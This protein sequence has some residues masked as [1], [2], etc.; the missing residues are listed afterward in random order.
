MS[1][2]VEANSVVAR[3][4]SLE[5]L[6]SGGLLGYAYDCPNN[7]FCTDGY[8]ARVGFMHTDDVESFIELLESHGLRYLRWKRAKD[9]LVVD[10][11]RGPMVK[12][13][14]LECGHAT[15]GGNTVTACRLKGA[16]EV[17]LAHPDGWCFEGSLS[18]TF[19]FVPHE[20]MAKT[21]TF[22]RHQDGVDVY[23][24]KLTGGELYIGRSKVG[25]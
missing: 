10:Q 12:C 20:G 18:Q 25:K 8:L 9:F 22:L 13:S 7:S 23:L 24:S 19:G 6:Y 1:V 16:P 3:V 5:R 15:G 21:M 14:W 17:E 4:D 2:L 11:Q